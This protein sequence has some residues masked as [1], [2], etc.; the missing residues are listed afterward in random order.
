MMQWVVGSSQQ[1]RFLVV[2]VAAA[3]MVFGVSH[4]TIPVLA[5]WIQP[6]A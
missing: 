2:V 4:H 3:I 6:D 1:S 5:F